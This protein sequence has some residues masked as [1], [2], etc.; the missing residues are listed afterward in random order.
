VVVE[1]VQQQEPAQ[2]IERASSDKV[3]LAFQP[4]EPVIFTEP[5]YSW[6]GSIDH[7]GLIR[8]KPVPVRPPKLA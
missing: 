6:P 8:T 2:Q 3:L 4:T 1:D 7:D 5:E